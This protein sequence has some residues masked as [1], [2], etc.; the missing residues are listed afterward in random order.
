MAIHD[1]AETTRFDGF[2]LDR[3]RRL[4]LAGGKPVSLHARALSLLTFLIDNRERPVPRAEILAHVWEGRAVADNNLAVQ[5]SALR[6]ALTDAGATDTPILTLPNQ[7][8]QFIGTILPDQP[9]PATIAAPETTTPPPAPSPSPSPS[10]RKR[11]PNARQGALGAGAA[12]LLAAAAF[13]LHRPAAHV[14]PPLSIAVMP[15]RNEGPD[16]ALD[17][18]AT[19]ITD[20]LNDDLGHIPGST[21]IARASTETVQHQPIPQIGTQLDVRY[22]LTGT[23]TPEETGYHVVAALSDAATARQ[24][25]SAT[26]DPERGH[27]AELR[28]DIVRHIASPLH[29]ALNQLADTGSRHDRPDDPDALDLFFRARAALDDG[30][31]LPAYQASEALLRQAL[32]KQDDFVDAKALLAWMLLSKINTTDDPN[33]I[34]DRNAAQLLI[35]Q[36]LAR[37]PLNTLALAARAALH[38]STGD[39]AGARADSDQVL[40]LDSNNFPARRILSRCDLLDM[41]LDAAAK[42]YQ[43]LLQLDPANPQNRVFYVDL[44]SVLLMQGHYPDAIAALQ[45]G[46]DRDAPPT[47]DL[48]PAE[49][50]R[51]F[52]IA[53]TYL[54]GD[55]QE[56]REA[57]ASYSRQFSGRSVWRIK[58]YTPAAWQRTPGL[59][60][61]LQA[62]QDAGMP[63]FADEDDPGSPDDA[64]C[65]PGDFAST[66]NHLPRGGR[67]LKTVEFLREQTAAQHALILD[68]GQSPS[69]TA[70]WIMFD[71]ATQTETRSSFVLRE[72]REKIRSASTDPVIIIGTGV[73]GC[74]AF[75]AAATLM[76][77]GFG[78]VMWFRGGEEALAAYNGMP[79]GHLSEAM[80]KK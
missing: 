50:A 42:D 16:R 80:A 64:S 44:G 45:R 47:S 20:D 77:N 31:S 2:T 41:K 59:Q 8:Y 43:R 68:I 10:P 14:A 61:A 39:C 18:L 62:L 1:V 73:R 46:I 70:G 26:F 40:H 34:E 58:Q 21:V 28:Q 55:V 60:R 7:H 71:E 76:K 35:V 6:K 11:F 33:V 9:A 74:A 75:D 12:L 24:L 67:V 36:A 23:L 63:A 32:Q 79:S 17:Y 66:P 30:T 13:L 51:L 48:E 54:N 78:N 22:V 65:E 49:Q 19:A 4:L 37:S 27:L 52:L 3:R 5:L 72:A 25:W 56:A 38:A 15:F 69:K 29:V 57:Y 53:A